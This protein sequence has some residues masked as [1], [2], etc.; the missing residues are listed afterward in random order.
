MSLK[1]DTHAKLRAQYGS[2]YADAA[3]LTAALFDGFHPDVGSVYAVT[4]GRSLSSQ[5]GKKG[6][7]DGDPDPRPK[8]G[9][10]PGPDPGPAPPPLPCPDPTTSE[11]KAITE[12]CADM[13]AKAEADARRDCEAKNPG[14]DCIVACSSAGIDIKAERG[15]DGECGFAVGCNIGCDEA[16]ITPKQL[17]SVGTY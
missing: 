10:D 16:T 5:A 9:D 1:P 4:T 2:A 3:E 6:P 17:G 7:T 15:P 13:V 12:Y 8:P 11:I 14:K